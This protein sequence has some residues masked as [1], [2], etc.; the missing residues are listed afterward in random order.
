MAYGEKIRLPE[1][2]LGVV[3]LRAYLRFDDEAGDVVAD[4][5]VEFVDTGF[6][7]ASH[8][9]QP[10]KNPFF[11]LRGLGYDAVID[12]IDLCTKWS[13]VQ[14]HGSRAALATRLLRENSLQGTAQ[15]AWP[16]LAK[17][18]RQR[19]QDF[20]MSMEAFDAKAAMMGDQGDLNVPA[21]DCQELL[22]AVKDSAAW[23]PLSQGTAIATSMEC[24]DR[25]HMVYEEIV[26]SWCLECAAEVHRAMTLLSD[27]MPPGYQE[28]L[29]N[30]A[31]NK[32][33]IKERIFGNK[34][35]KLIN[36]RKDHLLTRKDILEKGAQDL[37]GRATRSEAIFQR[38]EKIQPRLEQ[39][40]M[41]WKGAHDYLG[42]VAILNCI[43]N[44]PSEPNMTAAELAKHVEKA[45][46]LVDKKEMEVPAVLL[47]LLDKVRVPDPQVH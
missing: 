8:P 21:A 39:A 46:T 15:E 10:D 5:D 29:S 42:T 20:A 17:D 1:G 22:A 12:Y 30:P 41:I 45:K 40:R 36:I 18:A 11:E 9:E 35:H 44:R 7:I 32:K 38:I 27:C 26:V 43:I 2:P 14:V 33:W 31:E 13:A 6:L 19:L 37:G 16:T 34:Q 3:D 4:A 24:R 25:Y 28:K 23:A 47:E